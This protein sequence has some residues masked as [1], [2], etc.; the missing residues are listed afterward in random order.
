MYCNQEQQNVK[1]KTLREVT[2]CRYSSPKCYL[3]GGLVGAN[4][5][6]QKF[7]SFWEDFFLPLSDKACLISSEQHIKLKYEN[8]GNFISLYIPENITVIYYSES[9]T[10]VH[11]WYGGNFKLH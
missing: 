7:M 2:L 4:R 3:L 8:L 11:A 5:I 1:S 10:D 6:M 9:R